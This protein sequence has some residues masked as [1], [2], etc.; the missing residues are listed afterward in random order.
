MYIQDDIR[1]SDRITLNLGLRYEFATVIDEVQ[2]KITNLR[3]PLTDTEPTVGRPWYENPSLRNFGPRIGMAWDPTGTGRTAIRLGYGVFYDQLLVTNIITSGVRNLPFFALG[4]VI[5]EP[6]DYPLG[7]FQ[8]IQNIRLDYRNARWEP[9]PFEPGSMYRQQW[10]LNLQQELG[11][12]SVVTLAY[13]GSRGTH[14]SRSHTDVNLAIPTRV[15]GRIFFP[16]GSSPR[17]P[18]LGSIQGKSFDGNAFYHGLQA[19]WNKRWSQG[20]QM[21]FAY[22]YSKGVDD[23]S[24]TFNSLDAGN[25][26][27]SPFPEDHKFI[28]GPSDHDLTHVTSLNFTWDVPSPGN[29]S[30]ALNKIVGGWQLGGI[31]RASTGVHITP[32]VGFD[33]ARS[34]IRR[35]FGHF[36]QTPDLVSGSKNLATGHIS[37]W[38]DMSRLRVAEAGFF[39][40]LGRNT[41]DA[42]NFRNLDFSLFK[43]I[44]LPSVREGFEIALRFEFFN[45]LNHANFGLPNLTVIGTTGV[46]STAGLISSTVNKNREIQLG[47]KIIW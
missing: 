46:T 18:N 32:L 31:L 1:A 44:L 21:Q 3:S 38:F 25:T 40:N 37:G 2:N 15:N 9:L 4:S 39:G 5:L 35:S 26:F 8:K 27:T 10:N 34:A 20:L 36:G 16:V 43:R 22:T 24:G 28:R 45:V 23:F 47:M 12:N 19:G 17:N 13:I 7:G 11:W 29:A 6:G 33:R 41:T 42:P 14:M 30:P